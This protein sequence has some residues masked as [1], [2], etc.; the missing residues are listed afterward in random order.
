MPLLLEKIPL[1]ALS[2]ASCVVTIYAQSK[3][4]SVASMQAH[5]I[6]TRIINALISYLTYLQKLFL[7]FDLAVIYPYP[8]SFGSGIV[9]V[10]VLV[11]SAITFLVCWKMSRYP[12]VLVGWFWFLG[13]MIPMIGII[14]VGYQSMA[15]RYTYLPF[16]GLYILLAWLCADIFNRNRKLLIAISLVWIGLLMSLTYQQ[17]GYWRDNTS[18]FEHAIKVTDRNYVAYQHLAMV[19]LDNNELDVALDYISEALAINPYDA[20]SHT[21][22]G[23]YHG[24]RGE[25]NLAKRSFEDA[26]RLNPRIG[27]AYN[28]LGVVYYR[29]GNITASSRY[30]QIALDLNPD[31]ALAARNLEIALLELQ[32][33]D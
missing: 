13:S 5:A 10:A 21:T 15:D 17:V 31:F 2:L 19:K 24:K 16:I 18:L 20:K 28:N 3:W 1:L 25:L 32:D 9:V 14:Q 6:S 4:G 12:Y 29:M 11:L 27:E 8:E 7:P 30:Y 26:L 22:L 33:D 23:I